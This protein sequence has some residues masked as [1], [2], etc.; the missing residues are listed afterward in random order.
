VKDSGER[1]H[2]RIKAL[3][4]AGEALLPFLVIALLWECLARSGL[5]TPLLFPPLAAIGIEFWSLVKSGVLFHHLI[6]SAARLAVGF[7]I[8]A[9]FG[10]A[11]GLAMGLSGRVE[12]FFLPILNL[13]LPIPSIALVPLF[14]LWFGLGNTAVVMLVIFVSSLQI[15]FNTWTGVKI[16]D[17]RLIRVGQSMDAPRSMTILQIVL[18]AALPMILTGARLGLARGWIGTVAG[19]LVAA[20]DWGLG[21]MIFN[22]LQFLKTATML[23]GILTIGLMGYAIERIIFQPLERRTVVRW[24]MVQDR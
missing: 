19:E 7:A 23:V 14:A 4:G 13:C 6:A 5:F 11:I 17:E 16:A 22:A 21:W 20:T 9:L 10:L 24:G 2:Y 12:R 8:G 15:I 18:P 3:A 1:H